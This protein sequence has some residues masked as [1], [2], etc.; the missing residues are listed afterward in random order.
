MNGQKSG[1]DLLSHFTSE[2]LR[3]SNDLALMSVRAGVPRA[4]LK[5]LQSA[6]FTVIICTLYTYNIN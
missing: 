6:Y 1:Q 4:I 2:V 3:Q 5:E